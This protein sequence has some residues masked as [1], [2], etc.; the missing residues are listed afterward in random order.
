M[1]CV[2]VRFPVV[3]GG[4]TNSQLESSFIYCYFH[5][6]L[7][8]RSSESVVQG[9]KKKKQI[10]SKRRRV[11]PA[12]RWFEIKI[13]AFV[14]RAAASTARP[15]LRERDRDFSGGPSLFRGRRAFDWP[16]R[17]I[18]RP[19]GGR[20]HNQPKNRKGKMMMATT[21]SLSCSIAYPFLPSSSSPPLPS[22][23]S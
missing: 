15:K 10:V 1:T 22:L 13:S 4:N 9:G 21:T 18:D 2:Y 5:M 14:H 7:L 3:S 6:L 8:L 23:P 11:F 19:I 16:D 17:S 12:Q 20:V